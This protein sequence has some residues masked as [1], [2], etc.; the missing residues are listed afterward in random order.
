MENN[1][2]LLLLIKGKLP[3]ELTDD[4]IKTFVADYYTRTEGKFCFCQAIFQ[5]SI[6]LKS[7]FDSPVIDLFA[8]GFESQ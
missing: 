1:T 4:E 2:L 8:D 3:D 7:I 5:T 6:F